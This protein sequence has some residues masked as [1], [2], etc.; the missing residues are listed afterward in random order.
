MGP[1]HISGPMVLTDELAPAALTSPAI[2]GR[3][4]DLEHSGGVAFMKHWDAWMGA[5]LAIE[6]KIVDE[7]GEGSGSG[8]GG[9]GGDGGGDGDGANGPSDVARL[10]KAAALL[11]AYPRQRGIAEPL[12]ADDPTLQSLRPPPTREES[13]VLSAAEVARR[14]TPRPVH[15]GHEDLMEQQFTP[16][17][18]VSPAPSPAPGASEPPLANAAFSP[19]SDGDGTASDD[20]TARLAEVVFADGSRCSCSARCSRAK[21]GS[22]ECCREWEVACR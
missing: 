8:D 20:G 21:G 19:W 18:P 12:L 1:R 2:F 16:P 3:K 15:F 14:S 5:K 9:G 6:R 22:S 7:A 4:V 17:S 10:E 13:G 11:A